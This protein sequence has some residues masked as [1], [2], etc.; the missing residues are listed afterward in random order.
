MKK[1]LA[2]V[3]VEHEEDEQEMSGKEIEESL[4]AMQSKLEVD[5]DKK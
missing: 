4:K 3:P 2:G 1:L 5:L